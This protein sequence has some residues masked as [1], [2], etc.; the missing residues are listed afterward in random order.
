MFGVT[1]PKFGVMLP[2]FTKYCVQ[3]QQ[4]MQKTYAARLFTK[5]TSN[6][7]TA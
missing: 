6:N 2:V 7:L 1:V 3:Q 5:L 4:Q